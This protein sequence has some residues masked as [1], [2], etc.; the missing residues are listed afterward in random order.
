MLESAHVFALRTSGVGP[1]L[2]ACALPVLVVTAPSDA[3]A[4][5]E[6]GRPEVSPPAETARP[7][8]SASP[9]TDPGKNAGPSSDVEELVIHGLKGQGITTD[10]SQSVTSFDAEDL[11]ALGVE[12]VSDIARFTPNLEIRTASSTTPTFFIRGVGLNDFTANASGAVA[13]YSDGVAFNLP[14][15]QLVQVF[16]VET[17]EVLR[18]PQGYGSGRNASAG[19]IRVFSNKPSGEFQGRARIDYGNYNFVDTEGYIEV[20]VVTDILSTRLAFRLT[21]RDGLVTNNCGGLPPIGPDRPSGETFAPCGASTLV[22]DDVPP[23]LETDLNNID[24]WTAR[25]QVRLQPPGTNSDWLLSLHGGKINQTGTVGQ[26]IGTQAGYFGSSVHSPFYTKPEIEEERRAIETANGGFPTRL[27]GESRPS[28]N[29]RIAAFLTQTNSI[30]SE[31]L[32]DRPLST[33]PFEG[34]Y[35]RPG[36][37]IMDRYGFYLAGDI[38]FADFTLT[39]ISSYDHYER[40]RVID[41]DYSP[42]SLFEFDIDDEAWQATQSFSATGELENT[43][44]TWSTDAYF[45]AEELEYTQSTF[46][47]GEIPGIF[48]QYSQRTFSLGLSGSFEWEFLDD[49]TL[50]GGV[51]YNFE[52]KEFNPIEIYAGGSGRPCQQEPRWN[53]CAPEKANFSA[54]TGGISLTYHFDPDTSAYWKYSHGWK[55]PQYNAAD[56]GAPQPFTK[57]DPEVINALETGLKG[58]WLDNRLEIRAAA[59][60][61]SYENYQVFL[62][63]N[64]Y[65]KTPVRVVENASNAQLYGAEM[66]LTVEPIDRLILRVNFAWLEGKFLDFT[67][68]GVRNIRL[69]LGSNPPSITTDVPID[70]TGNRLP[71]TPEFTLSGTLEY[72]LELGRY[73][74]IQPRYDFSWT[75]DVF[76]DPSEGRGAPN[77]VGDIYLPQYAI[78]QKAYWLHDARLAY[79]APN[80]RLEV[81]GW[82]RNIADEVYKTLAF[83]ASVAANLVGSLVGTPRTYGISVSLDF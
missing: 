38:E 83:D 6:I 80:D 74:S 61:Y 3:S 4:Q 22:I 26:V 42:I 35:N 33:E 18:G 14:A 51:R 2:L 52:R 15:F 44:L 12:S 53:D 23:G 1:L 65:Q 43:P 16:D 41:A 59:F 63:T 27:P 5:Q 50:E 55:G 57:A 45:L 70:Y 9:G 47:N 77:V 54:P 28:F 10:A 13:V 34:D 72:T 75:D 29:A 37:E 36:F 56:A 20:P 64:D 58:S 60:W 25:G 40:E 71:N 62:T 39:S 76:F 17:I 69:P 21:Q 32:S 73:G 66:A 49:F 78:G 67:D 81:A 48:Q 79:R 82:V 46:S 7:G 24:V 8:D 30:L 31:S 11:T 68:S 19:A